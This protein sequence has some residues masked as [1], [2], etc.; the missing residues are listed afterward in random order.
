[1]TPERWQEIKVIVEGALQQSGQ[2][3]TDFIDKACEKDPDLKKEVNSILRFYGEV[4]NFLEKPAFSLGNN[5][6]VTFTKLNPNTLLQERYL[7]IEQIGQGG[8]GAV[9]KAQDKRLNKIVALKQTIVKSEKLRKAFE[10]EAQLL[11][12]LRHPALP[13]V[14]DH[15]H[16]AAGQFL[17]MEF[18]AGETFSQLLSKQN[19]AFN[20]TQVLV[21]AKELVEV[22]EYLHSQNP[23]IIHRDIKPNNLKLTEH[24]KIVLLDF[25]LAKGLATQ[26]SLIVE[27]SIAGYTPYYAPLEQINGVGTDYRSD[28]Y[29]LSATL[30]TLLT[31]DKPPDATFRAAAILNGEP[32]PL[33]KNYLISLGINEKFA[34]LLIDCLSQNINQRPTSANAILNRLLKLSDI[35]NDTVVTKIKNIKH[36]EQEKISFINEDVQTKSKTIPGVFTRQKVFN[37][38]LT[39]LFLVLVY[40]ILKVAY[41][42]SSKSSISK[43]PSLE[44]KV[45]SPQATEK[46]IVIK[47]LGEPG[48]KADQISVDIKEVSIYDLLQFFSNNYGLNFILDKSVPRMTVTMKV[49][50]IAW[51]K[52]LFSVLETNQLAYKIEDGVISIYPKPKLEVSINPSAESEN[53]KGRVK[54]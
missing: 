53:D 39:I 44:N 49:N 8:M 14:I 40:A 52:A 31:G 41:D 18:I 15:F 38:I 36:N 11:A 26:K 9:Y 28:F 43:I 37:T 7:I 16:E 3:R 24:N 22:L 5:N 33:Q 20:Q 21:W 34:Q 12:K 27:S 25:G 4:G 46:P 2:Q 29:S 1:M 45:T 32:D 50:D 6:D 48:F 51:D 42:P 35:D 17:V 23:P 30:Y 13:I 19:K 54:R 47:K 10:Q